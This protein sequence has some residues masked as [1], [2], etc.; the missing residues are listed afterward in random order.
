MQFR[1]EPCAE[2]VLG[3]IT[4]CYPYDKETGRVGL[5][6]YPSA[7][8]E[9]LVARRQRL[10]GLP[11]I[12]AIPDAGEV[13]ADE[14]ESLVQLKVVGEDYSEGFGQGETMLL[15]PGSKV[16]RFVGQ[17]VEEVPGGMRV[18]TELKAGGLA[19]THRVE[20]NLGTEG[21]SIHVVVRNTSDRAVGLE[22][23]SSFFL[24]GL[25]PFASDDAPGRLRVH[26]F[27]SRW[28]AE[29][30]LESVSIEDL[31]LERSWSGAGLFSERFGQ[32]GSMPVRKWFP[33]VALEDTQ[34]GVVW[35]A[36]LDWA[37]S[38][39]M[40]I[41][42]RNDSLGL[43][44]GLADREFGHWV[45][46][47]AP[48]ESFEAP[49]AFISCVAGNIDD[50]CHQMVQAQLGFTERLPEP[51]QS[52]PVMVNE[53]CLTWGDPSHQRM[54]EVAES[55]RANRSTAAYLVIDAGW[56]KTG[57][58]SWN[59]GH[60][61]WVP[62]TKLFPE[63]LKA[64]A[65]AIRERGLIPGIW[66]EM[67]TCGSRSQAFQMQDLLLHRDG[68]PLTVRS[69][70]FWDLRKRAAQ[71]HLAELVIGL[72][73][74]CGFGYLKVDYNETIGLG[75]DG[76]ESQGEGL[77]QH[78]EGVYRFFDRIRS[79]LPDLVIEN[80]SSG[81]HRLERSMMGRTAVSSS[82]DAHELTEIPIIAANLQ[83]LILPQQ[84]L[85]WAVLHTSDSIQ[86]LTYSLTAT[87]LGRMCLSGEMD[88]LSQEQWDVVRKGEEEY[89]KA[90]PVLSRGRS[91]LEQDIESTWRYPTGRQ[92]VV[93]LGHSGKN[94]LV[95][96]HQFA[97]KKGAFMPWV[98]E[99][100]KVEATWTVSGSF[101]DG[102]ICCELIDG[103]LVVSRAFEFSGAVLNLS[104]I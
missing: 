28:S 66:F 78:V 55:L 53:W 63:G 90:V 64:T 71:E 4:L 7:K 11:Y 62:S 54:I 76:A 49:G 33:F 44:G 97:T 89:A 84:S 45:K 41:V 92:S 93:R 74:E 2:I 77:R 34:A 88:R 14:I 82:S 29:A 103:K 75:C 27:R 42:R 50:L 99:L 5:R 37:G 9:S 17:L 15:S 57:E 43:S 85:I 16:M 91:T 23:L 3:S 80:C 35:G 86:R 101:H 94:C 10:N 38:W 98:I 87:F 21:L 19:I 47:L 58:G 79:E 51:E 22:M 26:R 83:R 61:D 67:E 1:S 96:L 56:Y 65:Q 60:G 52:L 104:A 31:H 30:R 12:D 95:V 40:E 32:L 48:E 81:G 100:P 18:I 6:I 59:N 46:N 69:R 73:K 36:Q 8:K 13:L 68:V 39:Q 70:R 25:T 24:G 72:I 20:W 102:S